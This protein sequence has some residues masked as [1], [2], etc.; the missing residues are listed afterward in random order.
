[1]NNV[2]FDEATHCYTVDGEELPS[3]THI[4]R[5][6][7]VDVTAKASPWLRD[8]AADRGSRVHAYTVV[9]DYGEEPEDIDPDCEG[10]VLAYRRFLKDYKPEWAGIETVMGSVKLGY[11]G[12]C[13][14]YGTVNGVSTVVD[15]KTGSTLN[16]VAVNSQLEG[17]DYLLMETKQ[18]YPEA[19]CVLH[20]R[21]DGTYD[22]RDLVEECDSLWGECFTL[23]KTLSQKGLT[24][25]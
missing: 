19:C 16:K 13:D 15:I 1:M 11:A 6:L 23:H 21:K 4:C 20:L 2:V 22:Y 12:T 9:L 10:Y 17:Y 14:R 18:F 3:V 8:I 7:S 24:L 25:R 5:F